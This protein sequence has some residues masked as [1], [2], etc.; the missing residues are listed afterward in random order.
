MATQWKYAATIIATNPAFANQLWS[1][2]W[3][4]ADSSLRGSNSNTFNA[5][6]AFKDSTTPGPGPDAYICCTRL[7]QS[8]Y[9][10]L[11]TFQSGGYPQPWLDSGITQAQINQFRSNTEMNLG[12]AD[13]IESQHAQFVAD[14]NYVP[15]GL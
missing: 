13:M 7:L 5:Q 6:N 9:D 10:Q 15:T 3:S 11:V 2:L 1:A 12:D 8:Q 14:R 4:T